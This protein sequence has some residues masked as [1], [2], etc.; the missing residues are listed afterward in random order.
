M[1][2]LSKYDFIVTYE[3]STSF[4]LSVNRS[5][6]LNLEKYQELIDY[7]I[8]FRYYNNPDIV[9]IHLKR[10]EKVIDTIICQ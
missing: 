8:P 1:I 3:R 6:N 10:G 2:D 7:D 4:F 9:G 5:S